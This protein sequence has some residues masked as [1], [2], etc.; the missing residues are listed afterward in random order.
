MD[1]KY[2]R[3]IETEKIVAELRAIRNRLRAAGA[4]QAARYVARAVKSADGAARHARRLY[5]EAADAA[6]RQEARANG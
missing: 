2:E 6:A 1:L 3:M 5:L 4:V